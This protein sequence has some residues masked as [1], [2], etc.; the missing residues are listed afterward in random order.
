MLDKRK[1][2]LW[3]YI[4]RMPLLEHLPNLILP[5]GMTIVFMLM[6][7]WSIRQIPAFVDHN[8]A[9]SLIFSIFVFFIILWL[10]KLLLMFL[11]HGALHDFIIRTKERHLVTKR[12]GAAILG[13]FLTNGFKEDM[14]KGADSLPTMLEMI[15]QNS[16]YPLTPPCYAILLDKAAEMNPDRI[17][18]VWDFAIMPIEDLYDDD[19]QN[20]TA[21]DSYFDRLHEIYDNIPD[22]K[23]K[24]RV[25]VFKDKDHKKDIMNHAGW[26]ELLK[27]HKNAGFKEVY[28]CFVDTVKSIKA[29]GTHTAAD[30][31]DF[32]YFHITWLKKKY[33]WVIGMKRSSQ[34]ALRHREP[35]VG[36]TIRMYERLVQSPDTHQI[37]L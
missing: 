11:F 28:W 34:T 27:F 36:D 35:V 19:G 12:F 24:Q 3:K 2:V 16:G 18:A 25:F 31:D 1:M 6:I 21:A 37:V 4:Y 14:L 7:D 15:E 5:V 32:V 13:K 8:V 23:D 17:W 30:M 9:I 22:K 20:V 10:Q 26:T 29:S 33:A